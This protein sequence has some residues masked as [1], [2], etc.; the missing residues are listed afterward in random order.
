MVNQRMR[1]AI[2]GILTIA[3][4]TLVFGIIILAVWSDISSLDD[5]LESV[6]TK[7]GSYPHPQ[8]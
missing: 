4:T 3:V 7:S 2:S 5:L 1:G 8:P 6:A